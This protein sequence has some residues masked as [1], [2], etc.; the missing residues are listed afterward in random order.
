MPFSTFLRK[1]QRL[2]RQ[3]RQR[4]PQW[5][6]LAPGALLGL[7]V[8]GT[9]DASHIAYCDEVLLESLDEKVGLT[10]LFKNRSKQID[11]QASKS[12]QLVCTMRQLVGQRG[13]QI[14]RIVF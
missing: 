5:S 13:Q 6:P 7:V 14:H 12:A 3:L 4:Q 8:Q 11:Q 1:R 9:D 10:V 2:R